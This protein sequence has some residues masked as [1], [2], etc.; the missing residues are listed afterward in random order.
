MAALSE[1]RNI[2]STALIS[3][4]ASVYFS[5]SPPTDHPGGDEE[6]LPLVL[7]TQTPCK[8]SMCC[9]R[10]N[11]FT[12]TWHL[13]QLTRNHFLSLSVEY[14]TLFRSRVFHRSVYFSLSPPT[15]HSGGDEES[16]PL[17][18]GT[19]ILCKISMCCLRY[20]YFTVTRHWCNLPET[21]SSP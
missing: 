19:Q 9:L 17:V 16:F 7:G 18:W 12:V 2:A 20:N 21:S 1:R 3:V 15:D 8:L 4:P 5:L 14:T 6:S 13:V 10:Y 11:Y